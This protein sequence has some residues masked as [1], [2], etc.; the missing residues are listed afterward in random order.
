MLTLNFWLEI[1]RDLMV[2]KT[3]D[4]KSVIHHDQNQVLQKL[5]FISSDKLS[6]FSEALIQAEKDIQHNSDSVLVLE[7]LWV[8]HARA[9]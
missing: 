7:N 6:F 8:T 4:E 5:M 1:V 2:M 9:N 3:G